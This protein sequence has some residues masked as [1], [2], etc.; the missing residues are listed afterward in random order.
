M[1]E[2]TKY[3]EDVVKSK[4]K[5]RVFDAV[6]NSVEKYL[7]ASSVHTKDSEFKKKAK[8]GD[9]TQHELLNE[10]VPVIRKL[11]LLLG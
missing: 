7:G 6:I 11:H 3:E 2:D 8:A 5:K 10:L 1:L 9:K 4:V